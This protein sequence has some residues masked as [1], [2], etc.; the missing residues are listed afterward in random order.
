MQA[1]DR[2]AVARDPSQLAYVIYT[3]GS[4]GRPKG[5]MIDQA[6]IVNRLR[7][8]QAEYQLTRNDRVLQK[9]PYS[10]D[11]SV[12]EFFWPLLSGARLCVAPEQVHRDP[13]ALAELIVSEQITTLHFVPSMLEPFVQTAAVGRCRSL[14][15]VICSGEGLP[16]DLTRRFFAQLPDCELHNLYGPTEASVDVTSWACRQEDPREIVPIGKPI[17]NLRCYVLDRRLHPAPL[18]VAGELY[19]AGVGLARGYLERGLD[20]GTF[21][22]GPVCGGP[23]DVQDGR[24]GALAAGRH[25]GA[26]GPVGPP[27]EDPR[28]PDRAGRD[29]SGSAPDGRGERSGL[30]GGA[31]GRSA[32][33]LRLPGRDR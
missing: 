6:G 12:W 4:T 30:C 25:A 21:C 20:G 29:R 14:R 32:D 19:L 24:P 33:A 3:S 7:W 23:A 8:M 22:A 9:T 27:G 2:L 18:G 31:A 16:Y 15:R 11:V 26:P 28:Q 17:G 5:V 10:F 1:A 13:A